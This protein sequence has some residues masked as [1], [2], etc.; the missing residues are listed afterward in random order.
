M[1]QSCAGAHDV[2][3]TPP[4]TDPSWHDALQAAV[5]AACH[6]LLTD[7]GP[8][9]QAAVRLALRRLRNDA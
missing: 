1:P 9:S 4:S 5:L 8:C 6:T 3:D 7:P 2:R